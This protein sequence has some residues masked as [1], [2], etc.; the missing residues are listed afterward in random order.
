MA[1][2]LAASPP[3]RLPASPPPRLAAPLPHCLAPLVV[4]LPRHLATCSQVRPPDSAFS[5]CDRIIRQLQHWLVKLV[6]TKQLN[7]YVLGT[8]YR[9][10]FLDSG[11]WLLVAS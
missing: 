4:S 5:Q 11:C 1:R 3:P 9:S 8:G 6:E 7:S 10:L 2:R